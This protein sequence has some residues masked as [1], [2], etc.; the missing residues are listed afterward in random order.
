MREIPP[1]PSAHE[2][3]TFEILRVWTGDGL[4]QQCI[5]HTTWKDPATWGLL[6]V[7]IARHAARAYA[8]ASDISEQE[9][10]TRIKSGID[11]EWSFP[12]DTGSQGLA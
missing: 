6:L 4:S 8:A 7:D 10:L 1:P 3:D 2:P 12:T 9:A 5:L 11:A